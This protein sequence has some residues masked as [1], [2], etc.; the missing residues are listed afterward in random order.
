VMWRGSQT[1]RPGVIEVV[2][3]PPV[4]TDDWSVPTIDRHVEDVRNTFM[5]TLARW[6]GRPTPA[7]LEA[8]S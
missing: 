7:Q 8:S 5:E 1:I 4:Q 2:V 3:C 6:P